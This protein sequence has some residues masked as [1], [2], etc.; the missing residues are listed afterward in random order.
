[1]RKLALFIILTISISLSAQVGIG[2]TTPKAQLDIVASNP[3][4]PTNTD[5]ILIPRV[6]AL[7]TTSPTADQNGMLVFLTTDKT[8]YYWDNANTIWVAVNNPN[9]AVQK[10]DDLGD[11]KSDTNGSSVFLGID[12]GEN[13]DGSNNQNIGVGFEALKAN[14]SGSKNTGNG[15]KTLYSNTTGVNNT[16][17]GYEALNFNT[18]ANFNT[19][20]GYQSLYS[21]KAG[22]NAVA[23]GAYAMRYA[24]NNNTLFYNYNVAIGYE[25]LRGSTNPSNNTGNRN[26]AVGYMSN[27]FNSTGEGNSSVGGQTLYYNT[28]GNYNTAN[29]YQ[30][31]TDNTTGVENTGVGY[32]ALTNNKGSYNTSIGAKS[33]YS[34]GHG[35]YNTA[36]GYGADILGSLYN[37]ATSIGYNTV[38]N[39]S[40]KIRL[41]NTSV[42]SIEG[43]VAY[44]FPSD[45]RFKDNIRNDVNG[46]DFIMKLEPVTYTFN[47]QKFAQHINEKTEAYEAELKN[48]SKKRSAGFLAQDV[49]KVIAEIGFTSF[50]AVHVP[51][52]EHDNYS[53]GYSLFVVPLVKAVQE[54]QAI[55]ENL[56]NGNKSKDTKIQ[57]LEERL[58]RLEKIVQQRE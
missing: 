2:A 17:I 48:L 58:N 21:N 46:L 30:A 47:R 39:S 53:L 28:T 57:S 18:T 20:L 40:N 22:S 13:D 6:D 43:Q 11:G 32:Q 34:N 49:E 16:A 14:S 10:I 37:N 45:A 7:P 36:I 55:I 12:A 19:A 54:Q 31:L 3:V 52:S 56:E 15:Y 33:L 4:T 27:H 51:T 50:D 23:I 44:T 26:T 1:M 38:V 41:G 24:N 9:G 5:G 29:G 42:T 8:F 25:A 35:N